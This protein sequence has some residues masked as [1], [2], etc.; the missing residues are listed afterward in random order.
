MATALITATDAMGSEIWAFLPQIR[1]LQHHK[2]FK[3]LALSLA[4]HTIHI[5]K[6]SVEVIGIKGWNFR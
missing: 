3:R 1:D 5:Y 4:I 6:F 2:L